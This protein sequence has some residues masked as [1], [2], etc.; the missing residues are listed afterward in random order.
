MRSNAVY[1][2]KVPYRILCPA[3]CDYFYHINLVVG[4]L[5]VPLMPLGSCRAFWRLYKNIVVRSVY[6]GNI[7]S[8]TRTIRGD[9]FKHTYDYLCVKS[10]RALLSLN[11]QLNHLGTLPPK[12]LLHLFKT[13]I[14][15]IL[16]YGGEIWGTNKYAC[17]E[18]DKFCLRFM[19]SVLG[20]KSSTSTIA[21]YG[22]LRF[23]PPS[24]VAHT[25]V[26]CYYKRLL[27]MSPPYIGQT[28]LRESNVV[29]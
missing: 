18:I 19:K 20:V 8:E 23:F 26:L 24:L 22:E 15:P 5:K 12:L 27:H 7:F 16:T 29:A 13:N 14:E 3:R 2:V 4:L 17:D 21:V 6:L 11:K 25:R 28:S 1:V 10:Q 9:V